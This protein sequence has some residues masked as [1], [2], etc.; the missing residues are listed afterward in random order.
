MRKLKNRQRPNQKLRE[1]KRR[2]LRL[3]QK[4]EI[5]SKPLQTFSD[6]KE[7]IEEAMTTVAAIDTTPEAE[8]DTAIVEVPIID[9][10]LSK[11]ALIELCE[12]HNVKFAKSWT[13]NKLV[14][15]LHSAL[16]A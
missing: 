12:K 13:K 5:K 10:S 16:A 8:L 11:A 4:K 15:A 3:K 14:A 2:F 1:S 6:V 9:M 7:L